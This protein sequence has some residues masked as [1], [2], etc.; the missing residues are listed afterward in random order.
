MYDLVVD[1]ASTEACTYMSPDGLH[2][3]CITQPVSRLRIPTLLWIAAQAY[4]PFFSGQK[5]TRFMIHEKGRTPLSVRGDTLFDDDTAL[6]LCRYLGRKQCAQFGDAPRQ[7][8][9]C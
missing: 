8:I 5:I 1:V 4:V 2:K 3:F 9:H 7:F 6:T